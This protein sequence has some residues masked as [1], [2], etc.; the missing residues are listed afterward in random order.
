MAQDT[1]SPQPE[2]TARRSDRAIID[3]LRCFRREG[4]TYSPTSQTEHPVLLNSNVTQ[5]SLSLFGP[6]DWPE[7]PRNLV[8]EHVC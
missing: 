1:L 3:R 8:E 5:A 2:I 7:H 6:P 4:Q